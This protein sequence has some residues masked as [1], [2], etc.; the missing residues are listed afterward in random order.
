MTPCSPL[1]TNA[2]TRPT[3]R[4]LP[5]PVGGVLPYHRPTRNPIETHPA[6]AVSG[7]AMTG[8]QL[9][10][11][12]LALIERVISWVCARRSL[13]GAD[14]EAVVKKNRRGTPYAPASS[15]PMRSIA[16]VWHDCCSSARS[17]TP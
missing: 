13:R 8:A 4:S 5:L 11:S 14:A 15:V 10:D 17:E 7:S 6:S 3:P 12:E 1:D 2:M 9:F 16:L